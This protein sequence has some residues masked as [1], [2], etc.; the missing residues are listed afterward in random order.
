MRLLDDEKD[1]FLFWVAI[2]MLALNVIGFVLSADAENVYNSLQLETAQI[3]QVIQQY[4]SINSIQMDDVSDELLNF[5][6]TL[7]NGV[8]RLKQALIVFGYKIMCG[9]ILAPLMM[10]VGRLLNMGKKIL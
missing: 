8:E 10:L 6:D 4:S 2:I 9:L 1:W 3:K 5:R 7:N